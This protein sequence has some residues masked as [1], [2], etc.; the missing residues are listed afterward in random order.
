[1]G[2]VSTVKSCKK[3]FLPLKSDQFGFLV[4]NDAQ[5]Y[6]TYEKTIF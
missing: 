6:E 2:T 3:K 1:M 4:Q 5:C